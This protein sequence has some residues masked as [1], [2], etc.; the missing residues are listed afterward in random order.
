[1]FSAIRK[2]RVIV[3][4]GSYVCQDYC[5]DSETPGVWLWLEYT[6]R[7][8]FLCFDRSLGTRAALSNSRFASVLTRWLP[9][10]TTKVGS[11][12]LATGLQPSAGGA[13][14]GPRPGSTF[15]RTAP[16]GRPSRKSCERK[17]CRRRDGGWF[18]IRDLFAVQR[19]SQAILNSPSTTDVGRRV[20]LDRAVEEA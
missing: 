6:E 19:C 7:R 10:F 18:R 11:Q 2:N 16:T 15:S 3:H 8:C 9:I 12:T 13:S 1:M 14:A 5:G 17:C 20:G 4:A